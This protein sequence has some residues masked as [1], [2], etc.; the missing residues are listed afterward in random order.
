MTEHIDSGDGMTASAYYLQNPSQWN[1]LLRWRFPAD[2]SR[3]PNLPVRRKLG[4]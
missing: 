4:R 3:S 2:P 1:I